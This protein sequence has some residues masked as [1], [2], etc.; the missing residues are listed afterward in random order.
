MDIVKHNI[1]MVLYVAGS[2]GV[3]SGQFAMEYREITGQK[4]DLQSLGFESIQ[5]L[6]KV[7]P[8]VVHVEKDTHTSEIVFVAREHAVHWMSDEDEEQDPTCSTNQSDECDC[9]CADNDS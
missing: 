4:L 5:D 1:E 2:E 8:D 7:L 3:K 6:M 9:E